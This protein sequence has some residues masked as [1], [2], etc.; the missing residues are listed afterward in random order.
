[1]GRPCVI[2]QNNLTAFVRQRSSESKAP[3][4]IL[5]EIKQKYDVD[6]AYHQ[7]RYHTKHHDPQG[8]TN[9]LVKRAAEAKLVEANE[10]FAK[11]RQMIEDTQSH[12]ANVLSMWEGIDQDTFDELKPKDKI[13]VINSTVKVM[14][15]LKKIEI[16]QQRLDMDRNPE[17]DDLNRLVSRSNGKK[18]DPDA[19]V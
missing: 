6:I 4:M 13:S 18:K 17:L 15:E 14:A 9:I 1:M 7:L 5:K 8:G 10:M 11:S 16:S 3:S 12:L 2:C 19:G